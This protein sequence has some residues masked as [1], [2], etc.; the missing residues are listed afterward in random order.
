SLDNA[1]LRR[2][3][4]LLE[5]RG[6]V[7]AR[8]VQIDAA[9]GGHRHVSELA[10]WG[11]RVPAAET[12]A[13][14]LGDLVAI[15]VRAAVVAPRSEVQ[16]WFVWKVDNAIEQLLTAGRLMEPRPGWVAVAS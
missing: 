9:S 11:Q 15:A 8:S 4:S 12:R 3:R 16:R 6:A 14:P 10:L 13:D 5:P 1:E 7:I 2:I